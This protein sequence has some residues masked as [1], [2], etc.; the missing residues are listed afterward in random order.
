MKSCLALL[1]LLPLLVTSC[2]PKSQFDALVLER[3]LYRSQAVHADSVADARLRAE[4]DS[5]RQLSYA[6][7]QQVREIEN[8]KATNRSLSDQV[9]DL[10]GRYESLLEQNR[11]MVAGSGSEAVSLQQELTER[12]AELNRRESA[13]RQAELNLQAREQR[14]SSVAEM[15]QGQPGPAIYNREAEARGTTPL[16][17][18]SGAVVD[19]G[20]LFDELKQLM[21]AV[22]DSGYVIDRPA[23]DQI[24]LELSAGLLFADSSAVSL[25][26]QRLLRRLGGTLRNY[27]QAQYTVVGHAESIDG[28]PQR[29]YA[30]STGRAAQVAVELARYG[31]DPGRV[32]AGG[33]GFYGADTSAFTGLAGS[34]RVEIAITIPE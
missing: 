28:D 29:A 3:N 30:A 23:P 25:S 18:T 32:V 1:L 17:P 15:R 31:V 7:E 20:I 34:R 5:L 16:D 10:R 24:H 4:A 19:A 21:V 9:N 12:R 2:V 33:K 14:L 11:E 6:R 27:P 8:L 13:L 22:T 26:G